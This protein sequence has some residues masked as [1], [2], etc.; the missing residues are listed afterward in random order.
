MTI[1]M[2]GK[3][4]YSRI[5]VGSLVMKGSTIFHPS[6]MTVELSEDNVTFTEVA[7]VAFPVENQ[8]DK[9]D[10]KVYSLSFPTTSARYVRLTVNPVQQMP[11]WH[12][13][14][15]NNA[16]LFIDEVVID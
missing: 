1:E 9:D 4:S 15:G 5:S 2:D 12:N 10:R 11:Q 14:K 3:T 16:F 13:A 6:A 7:S 8:G